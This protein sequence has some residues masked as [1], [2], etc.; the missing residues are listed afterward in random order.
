MRKKENTGRGVRWLFALR[1]YVLFF[2]LMAFVITCCMTLFLNMMTKSAGLQLTQEHIE[3]A[4]KVT[5][6]NVVLLSLMCTVID[7]IRRKFMVERPVRKIVEAAEQMMKGDFS[8]RIP[9][10]RRIDPDDGFGAIADCFNRMAEEL[11]GTETLRTDFIANVS[12]ELKTP[13][14]T[15]GGFIDGILDGTIPPDRERHYLEIVSAEVKRLSRLVR[16]M[17]DVAKIE[18]GDE[19][20]AGPGGH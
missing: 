13:M 2:L 15:I 18:A 19:D 4:A 14:T 11:S 5:F 20:R 1:R 3:Q 17:L 10:L 6:L 7:G 12:H 8:V 16:S 9:S